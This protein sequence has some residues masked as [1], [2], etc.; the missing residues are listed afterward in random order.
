MLINT[1]IANFYW[2]IVSNSQQVVIFVRNNDNAFL[3]HRLILIIKCSKITCLTI[4]NSAL[5]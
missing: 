4:I 5:E 2:Y 3:N 1:F